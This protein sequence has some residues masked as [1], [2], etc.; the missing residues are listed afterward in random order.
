MPSRRVA[1]IHAVAVAIEPVR[2]AF[3]DLWPEADLV[4]LLD[5]SLSPDRARDGA[6]TPA[7]AERIEALGRYALRAGAEGILYTCSAFGPA[8]AAFATAAP[9]PVLRPNE[10]MFARALLAGRRFG[11]LATFGP[12]VAPM[13][14]EFRAAAAEAGIEASLR[15]VLVESA[16]AALKA[17]DVAAHDRQL[18]EA[19][20]E[21][22]SCDAIMLAH[23]STSRALEA[24]S[25]V[26]PC[27]VLTSPHSA[28]EALRDRCAGAG[29]VRA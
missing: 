20:P 23:F 24:V 27:P 25:A 21:L 9:V 12:S 19:A 4:N 26:V 10:A 14:D 15:T 18:A 22:A 29:G 17:G 5:D 16:M 6:L 13:E 2:A 8:I 3:A 1:L 7:M 11:M 28:V